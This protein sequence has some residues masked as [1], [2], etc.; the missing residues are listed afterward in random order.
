M[1]A[2]ARA[3]AQH[4]MPSRWRGVDRHGAARGTAHPAHSPPPRPPVSVEGP[5]SIASRVQELLL[6]RPSAST[7]RSWRKAAGQEEQGHDDALVV[8][9]ELAS[10]RSTQA[11]LRVQ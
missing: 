11:S 10:C 1:A 6:P 3:D 5:E 4:R 8:L 9:A 7:T 2:K